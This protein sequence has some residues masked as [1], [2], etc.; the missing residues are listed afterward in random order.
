M[1]LKSV[2]KRNL[3]AFFEVYL[4]LASISDWQGS[5]DTVQSVSHNLFIAQAFGQVNCTL[6]PL[7]SRLNFVSSHMVCGE[8]AISHRQFR[9]GRE[10]FENSYRLLCICLSL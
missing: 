8:V 4:A 9:T 3:Q 10:L 7:H 2:F 1:V 6:S 5:T